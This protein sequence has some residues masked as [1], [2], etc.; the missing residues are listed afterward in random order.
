MI[1]R[2]IR[3]MCCGCSGWRESLGE[4]G[5]P[6]GALKKVKFEGR[7]RGEIEVGYE[8]YKIL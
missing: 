7:G 3:E 1:C 6:F 4:G 8:E 2:N 5:S